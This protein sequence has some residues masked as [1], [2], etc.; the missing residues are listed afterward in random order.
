MINKILAAI[1]GSGQSEKALALAAELAQKHDAHLILLC[2][3]GQDYMPEVMG[4]GM[5]ASFADDGDRAREV[6]EK[7]VA[8][9]A[10]QLNWT[11]PGDPTTLVTQGDAA[12]QILE[13]ADAQGVDM[14]VLGSHGHGN[15]KGLLVGSVSTKVTAHS[16][17]TCITV[18]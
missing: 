15:L 17:C 1:D 8:N 5:V 6:A 10:E 14:I 4:I 7:I 13:T 16:K 9:A 12:T 3:Y 2:V 18:R 11:G